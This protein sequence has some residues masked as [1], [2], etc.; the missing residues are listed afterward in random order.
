MRPMTLGR[1]G[2]RTSREETAA[3]PS[4][5]DGSDFGWESLGSS[6]VV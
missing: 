2:L 1:P 5:G 3:F 4:D 6:R